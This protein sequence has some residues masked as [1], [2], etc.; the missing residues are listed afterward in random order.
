MQTP[1]LPKTNCVSSVQTCQSLIHS[2]QVYHTNE[3]LI[4][5]HVSWPQLKK[6]GKRVFQVWAPYQIQMVL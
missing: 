3:P 5:G 2:T 4:C 6:N 1:A